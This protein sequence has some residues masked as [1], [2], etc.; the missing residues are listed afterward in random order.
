MLSKLRYVR[1]RVSFYIS[2]AFGAVIAYC[3]VEALNVDESAE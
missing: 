3:I 1:E 2:L